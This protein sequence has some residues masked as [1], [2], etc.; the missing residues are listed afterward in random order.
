M[1]DKIVTTGTRAA[2]TVSE[3]TAFSR[4]GEVLRDIARG[5]IAGAIVGIVVAGLGGRLLMRL[6]A[7]LN[8]DAVGAFTENG[9]RIGDITL[10]GTL[11]LI[12]FGLISGVLA[13]AL[14][15]IVG[16]WIPGRSGVR[17]FLTAGVA[18]AIGTPLL[19][20]GSNPDFVIL[21]HDARVVALLVAL[22]G[23]IGLSIA[24]L[25]GWL[26]RRLPHALTGRRGP[27]AFYAIVTLM[28]AVL[29][30]PFVLLLFLTSD[31]YQFPLRT[32]YALFV[33]GLCTATG[34]GLR[35]RGRV[36]AP[37]GLVIAARGVLV[38]AVILGVLTSLPHV[39]RA[40][41]VPS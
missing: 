3:Q 7:I 23:L 29:V 27:V 33:V 21:D 2:A 14:W 18:I 15:V 37:R 40:L 35:V 34:W 36:G 12:V 26:D 17:A 8:A 22:V 41:G 30:L 19:I 39:S 9:N 38:V 4:T 11:F 28:G 32:G 10:G 5:G 6:A 31:E 16:H 25:D 20:I 1:A 13:G 24:L